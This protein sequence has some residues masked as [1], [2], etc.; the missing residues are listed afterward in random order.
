MGLIT[1]E[2]EVKLCGNNIK[3]YEDLGYVIYR[4]KNKYGKITFSKGLKIKVKTEDLPM[5][6]QV[7]VDIKCDNCNIIIKNVI[8]SN[9]QRS[10]IKNNNNYYCHKCALK[11]FGHKNQI[12][13]KLINSVTFKQWCIENNRQDVLDRW[14]YE[15]NDCKPNEI[16]F[17][18]TK[19]YWFKCPKGMHRSELK[20]I[21]IFVS[22]KHEGSINCKACNS[23]AQ[24]GLDNL[25]ED[26]LD[27]YWDYEKN[28]NIDPWNITNSS[29][30]K[31]WIKCQEK[32]Y[33]GSYNISPAHFINNR[34]C[35]Y[36]S[37]NQGKVHPLDSL[38]KILEDKNLLHLWSN[39]NKED[40][41]TI[42]PKSSRSAWWKCPEGKHSDYYRKFS[43][44]VNYDFRC[45][46]CN[47]YTG[48]NKIEE[49]LINNNISHINQYK[50][51]GCKYKKVLRF[52]F[53][54]PDYNLLIEYQGIQHYEPVDFAGKGNKWAE[55]QFET[56]QIKDKIKR[57]YCKNNN[58]NLLEIPYWD[59]GM[60]DLI[61]K[62]NIKTEELPCQK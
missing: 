59:I 17:K 29:G 35:P 62:N 31:I 11:L 27:K 22:E 1:K 42:A 37:N 26:F 21:V 34:R 49:Y 24:W 23:F 4:N 58:I 9:Y 44:S 55:K 52:D 14:D 41:Y 7:F 8:W 20:N 38:G 39:K 56:N 25:G 30:K 40:P 2:V 5:G 28:K 10:M 53:Y 57:D 60:I 51:L 54:L 15:L 45:P 47:K 36:C 19:G 32:D 16:T 50:F 12:K 13:T 33:H 46:S 6:S 3:H 48:E 43:N 61:L 18:S